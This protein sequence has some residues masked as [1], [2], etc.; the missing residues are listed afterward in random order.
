MFSAG[1]CKVKDSA[2]EYS[3]ECNM[4]ATPLRRCRRRRSSSSSLLSRRLEFIRAAVVLVMA[5]NVTVAGIVNL[6]GA[7]VVIGDS[8]TEGP[9]N[10]DLGAVHALEFH[11]IYELV[12]G[13]TVYVIAFASKKAP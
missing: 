3:G 8:L 1:T 9:L 11:G 12:R 7:D 13:C 4:K 6:V 10:L 2:A 5:F